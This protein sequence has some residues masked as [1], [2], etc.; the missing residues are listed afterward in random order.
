MAL[1]V[2]QV[3]KSARN[4]LLRKMDAQAINRVTDDEFVEIMNRVARDLNHEA[5]IRIERY[6]KDTTSGKKNY[7]M[8]GV[9][10]HVYYFYYKHA[11][12]KDQRWTYKN[13]V[14]VLKDDPASDDVEIDIHYLRE[15]ENVTISDTDEIDLPD[16]AIDA[17]QDLVKT[18]M[19]VEFLDS[20]EEIYMQKLALKARMLRSRQSNNNMDSIP[21]VIHWASYSEGSNQYDITD[22]W[23]SQ[24]SVG[25]LDTSELIFL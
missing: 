17:F 10:H 23:V 14:I 3:K 9:I 20:N 13:D 25:T 22:Q 2:A 21:V 19:L 18:R 15:T 24:D 11:D 8:Q 7:E 1:T 5:E 12:W 16:Y 4:F 6:N